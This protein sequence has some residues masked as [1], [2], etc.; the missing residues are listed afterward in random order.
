[1][2]SC[3]PLKIMSCV[4]KE[5]SVSY[6][7]EHDSSD[8]P[9]DCGQ[10]AWLLGWQTQF[11]YGGQAAAVGPGAPS[12]CEGHM[13]RVAKSP[14]FKISFKKRGEKSALAFEVSWFQNIGDDFKYLINTAGQKANQQTKSPSVSHLQATSGPPLFIF[15]PL[16]FHV[17]TFKTCHSE[18]PNSV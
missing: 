15:K 6:C 4:Q 13:S 7:A 12:S 9:C 14:I 3:H 16:I 11:A 5:A 8:Q 1:M 18:N 2:R 17:G 10:I